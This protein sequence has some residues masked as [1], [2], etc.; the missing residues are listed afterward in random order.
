MGTTDIKGFF[1]GYWPKVN[2]PMLPPGLVANQV[3]PNT[4]V[5]FKKGPEGWSLEMQCVEKEV[6]GLSHVLLVGINFYSKSKAPSVLAEMKKAA[7]ARGLGLWLDSKPFGTT[8]VD[9][10]NCPL[11]PHD[12]SVADVV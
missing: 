11:E 1:R 10:S 5:D 6:L 7:Y 2:I 9:H 12:T 3:F 4:L 8:A